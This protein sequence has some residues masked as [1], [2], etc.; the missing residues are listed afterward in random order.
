MKVKGESKMQM[1]PAPYMTQ[2]CLLKLV[3]KLY[4]LPMTINYGQTLAETN[5]FD[6]M[7][8]ISQN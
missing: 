1:E 5:W 8:Q 3:M 2:W 4:L 7:C 6:S